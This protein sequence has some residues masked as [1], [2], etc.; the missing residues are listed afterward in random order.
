M[1]I[2]RKLLPLLLMGLISAPAVAGHKSQHH[3]R[4]TDF[5][6]VTEVEPIYKTITHRVPERSCWT[7]TRYVPRHSGGHHYKSHTPTILGTLIGGAI[8]NELGHSST[9][10]KV[11]AVVG[12]VL[13]ASVARDWQHSKHHQDNHRHEEVAVEEEVCEVKERV[14]YEERL[15]GYH[16]TYRYQGKTYHTRM[17][18]HPGKRLK[19]AVK[20][21]P[22]RR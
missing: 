6:K 7:E 17:D 12:G 4:H 10:K 9:N 3:N 11:G 20:V 14:E 19:V 1:S 13:G 21:T 22:V 15:V 16:V 8:G 5:A 2:S 18:D